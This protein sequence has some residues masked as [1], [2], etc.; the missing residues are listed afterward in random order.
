M[1]LVAAVGWCTRKWLRLYQTIRNLTCGD[2]GIPL[3]VI[4]L[5]VTGLKKTRVVCVSDLFEGRGEKGQCG[6]PFDD[7]VNGS[8]VDVL[9]Q[10]VLSVVSVLWG[11]GPI[12][13]NGYGNH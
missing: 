11:V 12:L 3:M 9:L 7:W 8:Y 10:H 5:G 4:R 6:A 1:E 2:L 13:R